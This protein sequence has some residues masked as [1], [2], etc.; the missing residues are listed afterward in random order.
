MNVDIPVL[1]RTPRNRSLGRAPY[2]VIALSLSGMAPATLRRRLT[3]ES[4]RTAYEASGSGPLDGF[5]NR[6]S[7]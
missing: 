4:L 3:M 2:L 5:R 1:K 6:E 7:V